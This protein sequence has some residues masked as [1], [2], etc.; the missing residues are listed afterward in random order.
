MM[1][2][3]MDQIVGAL[4]MLISGNLFGRWTESVSLSNKYKQPVVNKTSRSVALLQ[5][6]PVNSAGMCVSLSSKQT[7]V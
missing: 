2:K 3:L 4:G 1:L 5:S 6:I 7:G